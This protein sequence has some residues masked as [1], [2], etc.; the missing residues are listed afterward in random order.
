MLKTQNP[1]KFH[2][3]CMYVCVCVCVCVCVYTNFCHRVSPKPLNGLAPNFGH[4]LTS[5]RLRTEK[6][7]EV[8]DP[9]GR[10]AAIQNFPK[11]FNFSAK[12]NPNQ[13]KFGIVPQ[14][15]ILNKSAYHVTTQPHGLQDLPYKKSTYQISYMFTLNTKMILFCLTRQQVC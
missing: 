15:I 8:L 12:K 6:V 10:G 1:S 13:M 14:I 11:I 2:Y 4:R 7:L 3:V 9:Q 5:M